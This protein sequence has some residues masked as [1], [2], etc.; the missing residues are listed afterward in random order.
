MLD[1]SPLQMVGFQENDHALE[2]WAK[3]EQHESFGRTGREVEQ[4]E[5]HHDWERGMA[6]FHS[7]FALVVAFSRTLPSGRLIGSSFLP[8]PPLQ[9]DRRFDIEKSTCGARTWDGGSGSTPFWS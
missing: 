8:P 9:T 7:V 6:S 1:G 5:V 2:N 3:L 4:L